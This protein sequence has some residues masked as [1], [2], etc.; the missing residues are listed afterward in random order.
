MLAVADQIDHDVSLRRP[1]SILRS[2]L[3]SFGRENQ[4]DSFLELWDRAIADSDFQP[5]AN[6]YPPFI[7]KTLLDL[8]DDEL[9]RDGIQSWAMHEDGH[10]AMQLLR[11]AIAGPGHQTLNAIDS[12]YLEDTCADLGGILEAMENFRDPRTYLRERRPHSWM[13]E[14]LDADEVDGSDPILLSDFLFD[15]EAFVTNF[16]TAKRNWSRWLGR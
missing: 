7:T 6:A 3:G 13:N 8:S 9:A 16:V 5:V 12:D 1:L 4:L 10:Q 11:R 2:Y 15:V 14:H